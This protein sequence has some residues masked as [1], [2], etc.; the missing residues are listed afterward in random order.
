MI[1]SKLFALALILLPREMLF[2]EPEVLLNGWKFKV[3][4]NIKRLSVI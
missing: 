4:I 2:Y 1:R 3:W